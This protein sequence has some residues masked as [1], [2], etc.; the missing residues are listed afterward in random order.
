LFHF[1]KR[2]QNKYLNGKTN[3]VYDSQTLFEDK[4]AK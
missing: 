3:L 2:S 1:T 4:Y